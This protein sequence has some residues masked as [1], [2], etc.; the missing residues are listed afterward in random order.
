MTLVLLLY[1]IILHYKL[2][3]EWIMIHNCLAQNWAK[4]VPYCPFV[5]KGD[6]LEKLTNTTIVYLVRSI[7]LQYLK[8]PLRLGQIMSY[9]VLQFWAKLVTNQPFMLTESIFFGKMAD[10]NFPFWKVM[11]ILWPIT[12]LQYLKVKI[13]LD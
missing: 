9:K 4:L 6:F 8:K 11:L 3:R 10:V 12:L 1:R 2:F 5:W 7:M 13:K